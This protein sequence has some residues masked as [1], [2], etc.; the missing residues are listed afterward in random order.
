MPYN[1]FNEH[2]KDM[3]LFLAATIMSV[4]AIMIVVF[5]MQQQQ[6][7]SELEQIIMTLN[8]TKILIHEDKAREEQTL[9]EDI[10]REKYQQKENIERDKQRY[11]IINETN[12]S[13]N[14]LESN[15]M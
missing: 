11:L 7:Q 5:L 13:L 12:T 8:Q 1:W 4:V 3:F 9:H 10:E 15:V 6:Q 2:S 14:R